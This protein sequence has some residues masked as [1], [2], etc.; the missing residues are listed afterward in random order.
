MRL[1]AC[2][3]LLAIILS[4]AS[5][6]AQTSVATGVTAGSAKLTAQRSEQ[7]LSGVLQWQATPWL[8]LA[9][10]PSFVHVNDVVNVIQRL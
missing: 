8:S 3:P 4:A 9:T 7:A 5:L 2:W 6:A 1:S 10:V